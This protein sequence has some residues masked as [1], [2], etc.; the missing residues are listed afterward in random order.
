M[1]KKNYRASNNLSS[2]SL[3]HWAKTLKLSCFM[4]ISHS[5]QR[6]LIEDRGGCANLEDVR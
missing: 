4:G 3:K 1:Q 5:S 6:S 2:I